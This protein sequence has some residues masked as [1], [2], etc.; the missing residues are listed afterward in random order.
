MAAAR[1][2]IAFLRAVNV[3]GR[4]VKMDRLREIFETL[5]FAS[6][7]TFIASGNVAFESGSTNV[8]AMERKI[9]KALAAALGYEVE[10]FV[11]T[12][13]ELAVALAHDPFADGIEGQALL[14][15]FLADAP[16]AATCRVVADASTKV[17]D[18]RVHGRELYW[19]CHTRLSETAITAKQLARALGMQTTTRNVTTIRKLIDKYGAPN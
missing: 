3:G 6:V 1:R 10:T 18:L 12:P 9:E 19:R 17:D 11:R 7:A 14:L 16:D 5:G 4:V 8:R 13:A 2:Y 15:G